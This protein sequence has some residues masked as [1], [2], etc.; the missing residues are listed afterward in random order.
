M[1][2]IAGNSMAM[3]VRDRIPEVAL[4]R[5]LGFGSARIAFLLF[6]EAI[7]LGIVGGLIG[8]AGAMAI[9]AG[10]LNLGTITSGLGLIAITP[11]V[12]V[13]SI[14]VAIAVSVDERHVPDRGRAAGGAGDGAA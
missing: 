10:G 12:I 14:I 7:A 5:T 3:T 1:L 2:L 8:A 6:G 9:F 11:T 4:L 13:E